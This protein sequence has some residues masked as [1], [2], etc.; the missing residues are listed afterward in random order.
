MYIFFSELHGFVVSFNS[1]KSK[2]GNEF[3]DVNIKVS[4]TEISVVQF[5]KSSN[6]NVNN[7][8]TAS[9]LSNLK[10]AGAPMAFTLLLVLLMYLAV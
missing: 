5:M 10:E 1:Q 3:F 2:A 7:N 6:N 4:P 8:V 9:Y